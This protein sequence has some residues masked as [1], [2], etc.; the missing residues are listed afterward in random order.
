MADEFRISVED[1][2]FHW[3]ERAAQLAPELDVARRVRDITNGTM[4]VPLP[5]SATP[6]ESLSTANFFL[7]GLEGT[8]QRHASMQPNV[9]SPPVSQKARAVERSLTRKAA[10]LAWWEMNGMDA[11]FD[12]ERAIRFYAYARAPVMVRPAWRKVD[13]KR[14]GL[15][16]WEPMDALTA[17]PAPATSAADVHPPDCV[18]SFQRS[19]GWL[20]R[21]HPD[22]VKYLF[23]GGPETKPHLDEM[24]DCVR[25]CDDE[26]DMLIV[27]GRDP[28]G[29]PQRVRATV[30]PAWDPAKW[31]TAPE[32]GK[33]GC[34]QAVLLRRSRNLAEIPQVVM[35][36]RWGLD[37]RNGMMDGLTGLFLRIQRLSALEDDAIE[38]GVFPEEWLVNP[39]GEARVVVQADGRRGILGEITNGD[40]RTRDL[41]PGY[42]TTQAIERLERYLKQEGHIPEEMLGNNPTGVRTGVRGEALQNAFIGFNLA[43]GQRAFQASKAR[44]LEVAACVARAYFGRQKTSFFVSW[45]N[46][47]GQVDFVPK[48]IFEESTR[49]VVEYPSIGADRFQQ[50]Q[51]DLAKVNNRTMSRQTAMERDPDVRDTDLER[52]RLVAE[53]ADEA[54]LVS[55][56]TQAA[57][58]QGPYTPSQTAKIARLV[59]EGKTVDE[60]IEIVDRER[61]EQQAAA[62][63]TQVDPS[64]MPG[65]AGEPAAAAPAAAPSLEQLLGSLGAQS[66]A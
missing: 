16:V 7:I 39:N 14:I 8:A 32:G 35:P 50:Q 28:E 6:D 62:Q 23:V 40:I 53:R 22:E 21:N 52:R 64:M 41:N 27:V 63:P 11:G 4:A 17:Y 34:H 29:Y 54:V 3:R 57:N 15:P 47:R 51:A 49:F 45:A 36:G 5:M 60:A 30:L 66:A 18:F 1:A 26:Q 46:A 31:F 43:S 2:L 10:A 20:L 44:E 13:G 33:Y 24:F 59:R 61:Q 19:W 42:R 9:M 12:E 65:L 58:P 56:E 55:F 38:R 37:G 48:E 25:W